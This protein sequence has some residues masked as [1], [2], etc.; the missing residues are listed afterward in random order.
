MKKEYVLRPLPLLL[1]VLALAY[2]P[3]IIAL[4]LEVARHVIV[5]AIGAGL[6]ALVA[7]L[8]LIGDF[9]YE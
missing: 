8:L 1:A 9:Y 7:G 2:A 6:V 3:D 4:A 5:L